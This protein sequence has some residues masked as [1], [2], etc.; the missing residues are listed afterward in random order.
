MLA[1]NPKI[2]VITINYNNRK[3]LQETILSVIEQNYL[4]IE[5]IIIDGGSNDG[6]ADVIQSYQN[7]LSF[8]VSESD[9]GIYNAMNKGIRKAT[10]DYILFLNSGDRLIDATI[11][12]EVVRAGLKHDLI[13]GDLLFF[14]DEKEWIWK[15]PNELTF[16]YF[17]LSTI[18]HPSTF[19][20]RTLFDQVGMYDE[21][22]KIVSDWK[23]FILALSK[24][25]ATYLHIDKIISAYNFDGISS[26]PQ[27][28]KAIDEERSQVLKLNFPFFIADY[29]KLNDLEKEMKKIRYFTKPRK[30]IKKFLNQK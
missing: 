10:G 16:Q 8:W 28:L 22:L 17:Y 2:S 1:I 23:F 24:H 12:E 11:L 4:F 21:E 14:N 26:K 27:N 9:E 13:Y 15:F 3:G 7:Q 18:A 19:I 25:N 20:K 29:Q 5:Y 6:S 30:F